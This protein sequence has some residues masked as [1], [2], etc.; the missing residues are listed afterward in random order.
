MPKSSESYMH[1]Y[2]KSTLATWLRKKRC[3]AK[4][5]LQNIDC[6]T[7]IANTSPNYG[8]FLE[9]PIAK[10]KSSGKIEGLNPKIDDNGKLIWS[11]NFNSDKIIRKDCVPIYKELVD[12]NYIVLCVFDIIM[13][14]TN[15]IRFA[16]EINHK[17]PIDDKKEKSIK[18]WG[19]KCYEI[20]AISVLD[21][22]R[23]PKDLEYEKCI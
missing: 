8:V 21:N 17:H 22:T 10:N 15:N 1:K 3:G 4:W 6:G 13:V 18:D 19:I 5:C 23:I 20:S 16:F 9:Y 2:A 12:N 7:N 11:D 14:D